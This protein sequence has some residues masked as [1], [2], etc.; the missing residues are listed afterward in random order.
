LFISYNRADRQAVLPIVDHLH[1]RGVATFIDRNDLLPG[2]PWMSSVEQ[3][4]EDADAVAVFCGR[5]GLGSVQKREMSVALDR[6]ARDEA[7]GQTFQVI[8]V[9][10]P[11]A[12]TSPGFLI[13]NTWIDLRHGSHA[14]E[15]E[16][17]VTAVL[18]GRRQHRRDDL[19]CP[20][21][22][23]R[24]FRE[25]DAG[26]FFGREH[27]TEELETAL[28]NRLVALV[29]SSGSGKSSV[30]HA[31]LLSRLR[32]NRS[33]LTTWN[34]ASFTPGDNPF[35]RAAAALV[36]L[37]P[38][39]LSD[40]ERSAELRQWCDALTK[41]DKKL[42]DL[43]SEVSTG[44]CQNRVLLIADQFEELFTLTHH[45]IRSQFAEA[46]VQIG[47][48]TAVTILLCIRGDFYGHVID[49][50]RELSDLISRGIVNLGPMTAEE[51]KLAVSTPASKVGLSFEPGLLN[52]I[53]T[54]IGDS[55][56]S[57]PLV[58]FALAELWHRKQGN[59]LTHRA[60][61]EIG[62]VT[63]SIARR[64][65]RLFLGLSPE[66]RGEA[67]IVL[68]RMVRVARPEEGGEDTRQRVKLSDLDAWKPIV[69]ALIGSRL[70]VSS[71]EGLENGNVVELAHEAVIVHW[72]RLRG[73]LNE[74]RAFLLWRQR[75]R[76]HLATWE[77]SAREESALLRGVLLSEAER[78][79]ADRRGE[80]NDTE[81]LFVQKSS[82]QRNRE[83]VEW[84]AAAEMAKRVRANELAQQA[85]LGFAKTGKSSLLLAI[86]AVESEPTRLA[87]E[88]LR[89]VLGEI[90]GSTNLCGHNAEIYWAEFSRDGALVTTASKDG[91]ARIWDVPSGREVGILQGHTGPV[92]VARFHPAG[93]L[94]LTASFD[95]TARLW[96]LRSGRSMV[97]FTGHGDHIDMASFSAAADIVLT[98]GRD[99]TACLWRAADGRLLERLVHSGSSISHAEFSPDGSLLLTTGL[100]WVCRVW[101]LSGLDLV[102][103]LK[104]HSG[105]LF[106]ASFS[107]DGRYVVTASYDDTA[108]VWESGSGRM[109]S[110]L[111]G[112]V[113]P[114]NMAR[115]SPSM[116]MVVTASADHTARIWHPITGKPLLS[117]LRHSGPV[118]M[119]DYSPSGEWLV[120]AAWDSKPTVWEVASGNPMLFLA[121]HNAT[122]HRATFGPE[123]RWLVTAS[124]NGTA[125]IHRCDQFGPWQD[126]LVFARNRATR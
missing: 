7:S 106:R 24:A 95:R 75:M 54:G 15:L 101:R 104:G 29:G 103:E 58:E 48:T 46:L 119:C 17:L 63:G 55:R 50:N 34:A 39:N 113:A 52:R 125:C 79:V 32:R 19:P 49:L 105:P 107:A 124:L 25:E 36:P 21:V 82:E 91:T 81:T 51:L 123:S 86:E 84:N 68:T 2:T 121:G 77:L 64:A 65:E 102:A 62:E 87:V 110:R 89:Q 37:A 56:G 90:G 69:D 117:P 41:G 98:C 116:Q 83:T 8:P 27:V 53:L 109:I 115:F 60:Y 1:S 66:A 112:H 59:L 74:D 23:L 16:L 22:G 30:V 80:I 9:L 108:A 28:E 47:K 40:P 99:G 42:T 70:L 33:P 5:H 44:S 73:W 71:L 3:A 4:L 20:Y 88:A 14:E 6:Q 12:D 43:A 97:E 38:Q 61:E 78:W 67:R 96:E 122:S 114:V 26:L 94:L 31:G 92:R 126:L 35:E 13:Q 18:Y 93:H 111:L 100:D 11:G 85:M 76:G 45:E 57:L 72:S 10:L 120:T 118:T